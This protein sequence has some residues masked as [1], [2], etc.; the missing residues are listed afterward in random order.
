MT[1][2]AAA[3]LA[4]PKDDVT[5]AMTDRDGGYVVTGTNA[6]RFLPYH[7]VVTFPVL[8]NLAPSVSL[9][10]RIVLPP[11][12]TRELVVL[13]RRTE[14]GAVRVSASYRWGKGD[15]AAVPD[16]AARYVF[17]YEHGTK[18][19]V[20][21]GYHGTTTHQGL[22]ALDFNLPEG[23]RVCAARDGVVVGTKSDSN[24]GGPGPAYEDWSNFVDVLHADGTWATYAHLKRGGALVKPGERVTAGQVIGLSGRTG[25][26][27]GP[28]LHFAV[29]RASWDREG[30]ESIP[31]LFTHLD[32][33]AV[34]PQEGR[35]Y[36]AVRPGGPAFVPVLGT[37]LDPAALEARA[38]PVAA[39]GKIEVR[40]EAVDETTLLWCANGTGKAQAVTVS[41]ARITGWV[42]SR[43]VPYTRVVPARTEVY[44]FSLAR[45]AAGGRASYE[46]TWSWRPARTP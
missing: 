43:P 6:S 12:S 38:R 1:T 42:P 25:R 15:P 44:L 33:E 14:G 3:A 35:T 31:T 40:S 24:R 36:Y 18:R 45:P 34:T 27:S 37:R 32:G 19:T 5:F 29:Y 39:T 2:A 17:P 30:G 4:G 8:E 20:D 16:P 9:P 7:A 11:A 21:Q 10:A 46:V 26:A 13:A 28:H 22:Y 23:T 41:F